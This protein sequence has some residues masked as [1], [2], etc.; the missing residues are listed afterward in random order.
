[1]LVGEFFFR[2]S[3]K[4]GKHVMTSG[5]TELGISPKDAYVYK[6]DEKHYQL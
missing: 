3:P 6:V 4:L 5:A 2:T 1:M